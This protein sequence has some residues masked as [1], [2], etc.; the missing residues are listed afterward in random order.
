MWCDIVA[1]EKKQAKRMKKPPG[2][3]K[4]SSN[5]P[6]SVVSLHDNSTG[7]ETRCYRSNEA[8]VRE[9]MVEK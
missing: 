9:K 1:A 8:K 5:Q 2:A 4:K 3:K 6:F 7:A